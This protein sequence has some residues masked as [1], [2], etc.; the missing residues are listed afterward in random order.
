VSLNKVLN[1]PLFRKQALK[2]GALKPI[3][4]QTG[5]MVGSPMGM[6][7]TQATSGFMPP[8]VNQ[9]G[10]YGRN[11]RPFFQRARTGIAN[12]PGRIAGDV[13]SFVANPRQ[14]LTSGRPGF[15]TAAS[16]SAFGTFP[17]MEEVT[18][19]LGMT[20]VPK[21]VVDLLGA[22]G[23]TRNPYTLGLGLTY[24]G[25]RGARPAVAAL[26]DDVRD[27][28]Q[29]TTAAD[30]N[31]MPSVKGALGKPFEFRS[32]EEVVKANPQLSARAE[33]TVDEAKTKI[34]SG[35]GAGDVATG[36]GRDELRAAKKGDD[37]LT[38]KDNETQIGNNQF[39]DLSKVATNASGATPPDAVIAPPPP[40]APVT[41]KITTEKKETVT[42]D[43]KKITE[44][45][46]K[47]FDQASPFA[48]QIEQARQI[49][50]EL[51]GGRTSNARAV[52]LTNLAS[53]LLT[54][55]TRRQGLGGALEVLGQ[56]L[57]PAVNNSVM[58]QMKED[59]L[60]QKLLG[61]ALEFSN[62]FLKAQNEA[63]ALPDTKEVGVI[64]YINK[65][66]RIVNVAGRMLKDGTK[67]IQVPGVLNP[68]GTA[69]YR[70]APAGTTFI[71]NKDMNKETLKAAGDLGGKYAALNLINRS[72]GIIEGDKAQAGVV[73]AF[74][75][76]SGRI[77]DAVGDIFDFR[78]QNK[79]QGRVSFDIE[80]DKVA[81]RL[82]EAGEFETKQQAKNYLTRQLGSFDTIYKNNL[83]GLK[84]RLEGGSKLD[85]E[86]LAINETVLVYRLANSLKSKDRLT[87]KDIQM[88]KEL[89]KV[90]PLFRGEE[91]VISALIAVGETILDDIK[92]QET[93]YLKA[94]GSTEFLLRERESYGLT[95]GG[96]TFED[97]T[98]LGVDFGETR[99]GIEK[100]SRDELL[101]RLRLQ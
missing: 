73:G 1:R 87:Q 49:A 30:K 53:G 68:N 99:K 86:R 43:G 10:F 94:G 14:A 75:L 66:K 57:G 51:K 38:A 98:D 50:N 89:V 80:Q 92:Q 26:V 95:K 28:P 44:T 77:T 45:E 36:I 25:Y 82:V 3:T 59:E 61:R 46:K 12:L 58:I 42:D 21:D 62:S 5:I 34:A 69:V 48:K 13:R 70:T 19:K 20:G 76:Y 7:T 56:A 96:T 29:G 54:G 72:L 101:E 65:N 79:K 17:I 8:A 41:E 2:K 100:L 27:L 67:Q 88:A 63:Y 83:K 31:F 55:T 11:I 84:D 22:Y 35:R 39:V 40:P 6:N 78:D 33:G 81:R 97:F 85:Y 18:R 16:L 15:G 91:S 71:A 37:V 52:F 90:F 32:F 60:D 9:Q 4:A 93:Q 64:Q 47:V 24:M 23:M 74:G